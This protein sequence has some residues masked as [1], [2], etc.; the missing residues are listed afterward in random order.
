LNILGLHIK[1]ESKI[2][3]LV[4]NYDTIGL[5]PSSST[6]PGKYFQTLTSSGLS[7]FQSNPHITNWEDKGDV[8]FASHFY[9]CRLGYRIYFK[10]LYVFFGNYQGEKALP[11]FVRRSFTHLCVL[12][13]WNPAVDVE[14]QS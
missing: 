5:Q 10:P 4:V 12:G 1:L 2:N 3:I 11:L 8:F 13:F 14:E 9:N 6:F 7:A